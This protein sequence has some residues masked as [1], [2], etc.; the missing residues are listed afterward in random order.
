MNKSLYQQVNEL[1]SSDTPTMLFVDMDGVL[2]EYK[3]GE[4][5]SILNGDIEVYLDKRPIQTVIDIIAK[6][7]NVNNNEFKILTSCIDKSQEKAKLKWVEKYM[8]FFNLKDFIC[9]LSND[10]N[11][12]V[13]KKVDIICKYARKRPEKRTIVIE[14][15]HIIL[16]KCWDKS[17]HKIL[18][19]HIIN[20]IK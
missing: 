7:Y 4:G 5:N 15:T 11:Q 19:V 17:Q 14:D 13:D 8:Q 1:L 12:R 3:Y 20:L 6:Y 9:V 10:F 16:K 18:P 2:T